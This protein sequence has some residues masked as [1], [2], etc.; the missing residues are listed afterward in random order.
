MEP[1][2]ARALRHIASK[3]PYLVRVRPIPLTVPDA[4]TDVGAAVDQEIVYHLLLDERWSELLDLVHRNREAVGADPLLSHAVGVFVDAFFRRLGDAKARAMK[5]ELETLFLLHSGRYYRLDADRFEVVVEQLVRL[6]DDRPDAAVGYARHCPQ[7]PVCAAVLDR[8]DLRENVEHALDHRI[9][10][11][12]TRP[13]G[14]ADLTIGLFRSQ[15]EEAFFMAVREVFASYFPYPNVALSCLL[16]FESLRPLLS[17]AERT[18]FFHGV[19]DCVVFDQQA[20]YRPRYFFELDSPHHDTD[21][22]REKDAMK[23]RIL[24]AAGKKLLRIRM[25]DRHV[26]R[27]EFVRMLQDVVRP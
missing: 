21:R 9:R 15:Q 5:K 18:F 8:Q 7:N 22:G 3:N 11:D 4:M 12:E 23:D 6:H 20:G 10:L 26:G 1:G 17:A 14:D 27:A 2:T 16:D 13:R 24:S 25:K 19:V